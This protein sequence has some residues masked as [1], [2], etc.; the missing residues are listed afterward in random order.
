MESKQS[1]TELP[2]FK[3]EI[4]DV[5][6]D[7]RGRTYDTQYDLFFT[8]TRIIAAIVLH[9]SDLAKAYA[10]PRRPEELLIGGALRRQGIKGFM[11]KME[12]ERRRKFRNSAPDMI[13][14]THRANVE[15]SYKDV[16]SA[17]VT[18]GISG[19]KLEFNTST[20]DGFPV[21]FEFRLPSEQFM[22][23]KRLLNVAKVSLF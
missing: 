8:Q 5:V 15:I 14:K 9:P 20:K 17:K 4:V 21:K 10:D 1:D 7:V 12:E 11:E 3:D 23:V 13:L 16:V 18:K 6:R 19:V 2:I 22:N